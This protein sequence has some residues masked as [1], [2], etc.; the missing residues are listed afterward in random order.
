[1]DKYFIWRLKLIQSEA[2]ESGA[3]LIDQY[4]NPWNIESY[5]VTLGPEIWQQTEGQID[6]FVAGIGT[7]GTLSG[8]ARYLKSQKSDIKIVAVDPV[9]A[10]FVYITNN[11]APH[12]N[13]GRAVRRGFARSSLGV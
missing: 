4:H 12:A 9:V 2:Q 5:A 10:I 3:F 6:L 13:D 8:T 11:G 1:M 7:G